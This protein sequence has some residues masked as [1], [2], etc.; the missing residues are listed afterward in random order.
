MLSAVCGGRGLQSLEVFDPATGQ[1]SGGTNPAVALPRKHEDWEPPVAVD[2]LEVTHIETP[3]KRWL[4]RLVAKEFDAT[5]DDDDKGS[6]EVYK[7]SNM[8]GNPAEMQQILQNPV[9]CDS[10]PA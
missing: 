7:E 10:Q 1:W 9:V 2:V 8:I 6:G 3:S 5:K 4:D